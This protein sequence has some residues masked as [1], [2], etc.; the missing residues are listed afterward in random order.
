MSEKCQRKAAPYTTG[1]HRRGRRAENKPCKRPRTAGSGG[2][3]HAAFSRPGGAGRADRWPGSA[4]RRGLR[5][6]GALAQRRAADLAARTHDV[7][8]PRGA[9]HHH[10]AGSR[11]RRPGGGTTAP[12][13]PRASPPHPRRRDCRRADAS[14]S[15]PGSGRGSLG[16]VRAGLARCRRF[17]GAVRPLV[18]L[19]PAWAR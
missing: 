9:G 1:M 16:T 18:H 8:S 17:R 10:R 19:A 5:E 14:R 15:S 2:T 13:H 3:G 4:C 6:R 11:S 12:R 7:R